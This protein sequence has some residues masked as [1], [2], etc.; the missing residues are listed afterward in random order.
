[1]PCERPSNG[2]RRAV[3]RCCARRCETRCQKSNTACHAA[4]GL[5]RVR[6]RGDKARER[7]ENRPKPAYRT[8][9]ESGRE[10][11]DDV[12]GFT[13]RRLPSAD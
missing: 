9:V 7:Y 8:T 10:R 3:E 11:P 4:I 12:I 5:R 6:G 13:M 1:M 2:C